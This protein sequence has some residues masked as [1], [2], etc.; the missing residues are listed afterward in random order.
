M[1]A[2]ASGSQAIKA[3][4]ATGVDQVIAVFPEFLGS[5]RLSAELLERWE[6]AE[7]LG[8]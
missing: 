2:H 7:D 3:I 6:S 8:G 4:S 1:S 5:S